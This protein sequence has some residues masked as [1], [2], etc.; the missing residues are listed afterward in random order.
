GGVMDMEYLESAENVDSIFLMSQAGMRQGKALADIFDGA[1]SPSGKLTDTWAKDY[2]DYASSEGFDDYKDY[3]D[4]SDGIYVGYRY[5]D[6]F[7]K[8]PRYEFGFGKSYTDFDIDVNSVKA[9]TDEVTVNATVTNTGSTYSGKEV[10][11]VYFSSP[12]NEDVDKP[13]QELAAY[14]KTDTLA[15]GAKQTIEIKFNTTDMAYYSESDAAYILDEGDYLVRVG[16]SSRNTEVAAKVNVDKDYVV[17]QLSTQHMGAEDNDDIDDS[18][19]EEALTAENYSYDSEESEI[20]A[21]PTVNVSG[22]ETVNHASEYD[23][24]EVTTYVTDEDTY[25]AN[26]FSDKLDYSENV[27]EVEDVSGAKLKDVASGDVDINAFVA[28]ISNDALADIVNGTGMQGFTAGWVPGYDSY[29]VAGAAGQTTADYEDEYGIPATVLSDGPAGLRLS[30]SYEADDGNTYYQWCTAF[31]IGTCL[32]QMWNTD[33]MAE[34]GEAVGKEMVEYGVTVWL[35]PGMN[36]HRNPLC[37]RNFEYYSED[38]FLTGTMGAAITLGVQKNDGVGTEIK[39][40]ATNNREYNRSSE[41]NNV[42][43]RAMREIYL[44]GF[45]IAVKTAQP[46]AVMTCYNKINGTY[47]AGNY[48]TVTDLLRGEWDFKG[49]VTTDWFSGETA[50]NEMHAG[51]DMIQ[52]GYAEEDVLSAMGDVAPTFSENGYVAKKTSMSGMAWFFGGSEVD[53]WGDFVVSDNSADQETSVTTEFDALAEL[54]AGTEVADG[55][56]GFDELP[57]EMQDLISSGALEVTAVDSDTWKAEYFGYYEDN[58]ELYL[59][60]VQR[61]AKRI[62]EMVMASNQFADFAELDTQTYYE[63]IGGEL[64]T[65]QEVSKSAVDTGETTE[66][67]STTTVYTSADGTQYTITA[68]TNLPFSGRKMKIGGKKGLKVVVSV[69]GMNYLVKSAKMANSKAAGTASFTIKSLNRAKDANGNKIT[70]KK[71]AKAAS[72]AIKGQ[73]ISFTIKPVELESSKV[74]VKIKS[75]TVKKVKASLSDNNGK[76]KKYVLK[77]GTDYN[78]SSDGKTIE[79]TGNYKGSIAVDSATKM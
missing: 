48:D 58:N 47:G 55:V 60:D 42:S 6:T 30:Q 45:E 70:D 38:P 29:D 43:E 63:Y 67:T 31:P 26:A 1:V 71:A 20:S 34:V 39:H 51:N 16:D 23:D 32:A 2:D 7:N 11:E 15:P 64:D 24:E 54:A 44:K 53:A 46:M 76:Y 8:T 9:N 28:S 62:L 12:E 75:N 35:A 72:K 41:D 36:I 10:V 66:A 79:L 49:V 33:L 22:F 37:G 57:E 61:S 13:Y 4:Y 19:S 27:V 5:F 69:N 65:V 50:A 18:I 25:S 40:Y 77:S 73:T 68:P 74:F 3:E 56:D 52:P 59:G 14:G 17:E 78:L 21:A